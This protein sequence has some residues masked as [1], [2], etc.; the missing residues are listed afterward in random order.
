MENPWQEFMHKSCS[1]Q[2]ILKRELN[3]IKEFNEKVK[4][5]FKIHTNIMPAPFMGDVRN[6]EVMI[7]ALNPGY[8]VEEEKRGFYTKYQDYWRSE[9]QHN[10]DKETP[11][12]CLDD[13][14]CEYS[15]YWSKVLN[16]IVTE[17]GSNGKDIVAKN[18]CKVQFFPYQSKK[19]KPI[20]KSILKKNGMNHFLPSQEYTFELVKNAI[21]R[22]AIIIIPRAIKKWE[23]A[24]VELKEYENKYRTNSY[25]NIILSRN[26][27]GGGSFDTIINR[28][29]LKSTHL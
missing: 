5:N 23:S 13:T 18:V 6:A 28:L 24:I 29:R 10:F 17:L 21:R 3:V 11:L 16:P 2:F 9:I 15:H 14:Y 20:H 12:F 7:L 8:D 4:D 25:G 27:L 19:F 22:N 1:D 26:N